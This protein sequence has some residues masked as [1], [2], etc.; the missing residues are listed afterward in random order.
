LIWAKLRAFADAAGLVGW[1]VSVDS[2]IARAHQHSA[3]ARHDHQGQVE[4]PG[5]EPADHGLGRS[6]G[7]WTTKIHLACEQGRKPLSVVLTAGHRGDSPQFVPVLEQVSV[8]RGGPGRPRTRP[9]R[10]LA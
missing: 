6:R 3:G 5:P 9:E 8:S 1:S 2:T 10:V 7:G 4:P